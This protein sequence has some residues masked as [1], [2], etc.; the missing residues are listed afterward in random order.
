ML[1]CTIDTSVPSSPHLAFS[2]S[3]SARPRSVPL[4]VAINPPTIDTV[5]TKE[6]YKKKAI[7]PFWPD[8]NIQA[9]IAPQEGSCFMHLASDSPFLVD[10][11]GLSTRLGSSFSSR[12]SK[13]ESW[14]LQASSQP[15]ASDEQ[16]ARGR[17]PTIVT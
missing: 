9:P 6:A 2:T 14:L 11:K 15:L 4:R 3:F 12:S 8:V 1:G 7:L 10:V 16:A 5:A 17:L 13:A